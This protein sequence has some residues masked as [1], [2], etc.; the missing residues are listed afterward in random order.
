M[1]KNIKHIAGAFIHSGEGEQEHRGEHK[2]EH[3][4][5][6]E[7][8]IGENAHSQS[9][10]VSVNVLQEQQIN[11]LKKYFEDKFPVSITKTYYQFKYWVDIFY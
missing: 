4:G 8:I 1:S 10:G 6:Q 5:E 2:G 7:H 3:R 9:P 11:L